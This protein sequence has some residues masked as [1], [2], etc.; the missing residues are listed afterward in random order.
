M[1]TKTT[2]G[3]IL[4]AVGIAL[5]LL[6]YLLGLQTEKA[7]STLASMFQWIGTIAGFFVI[8]LGVRAVRDENNDQCLTFGQGF[9]A[10]VVIV[11][12]AALIS[13]VYTFVHFTFI[14]PDYAD[15]MMALVEQKWAEAGMNDRQMEA[16]EKITRMFFH[17]GALAAIGFLSQMFFGVVFSLVVAAIVKRNPARSVPPPPVVPTS[18]PP[19]PM[20]PAAQ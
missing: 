16:A 12:V 17:P 1:S 2:Y 6:G 3:L 11:L 4:A 5:A 20:P 8:W 7:G 9:G 10:G 14:N 19:P 13:A 18:T 15:H